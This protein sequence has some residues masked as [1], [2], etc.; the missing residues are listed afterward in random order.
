[1]SD[2]IPTWENTFNSQLKLYGYFGKAFVAATEAGYPFV[3]WNGW[4]YKSDVDDY[5]ESARIMLVED[6]K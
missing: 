5:S 3:A 6:L 4:V 2:E 1:M